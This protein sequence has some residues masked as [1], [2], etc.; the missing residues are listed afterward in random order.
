MEK[1]F[2]ATIREQI[3]N[4]GLTGGAD[5]QQQLVGAAF[6]LLAGTFGGALPASQRHKLHSRSNLAALHMSM[7]LV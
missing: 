4:G 2:I 5:G 1:P 7:H 3:D 6:A